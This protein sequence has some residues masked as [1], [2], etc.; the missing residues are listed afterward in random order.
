M[1]FAPTL[2]E[3]LESRCLLSTVPGSV[4]GLLDPSPREQ[5]TLELINRLRADPTADAARLASTAHPDIRR[6]YDIFDV[7]LT[8]FQQQMAAYNPVQ[9]LAWSHTLAAAAKAHNE[10]LIQADIQSHQAPGEPALADRIASAGYNAGVSGENVYAY[11]FDP[12][13]G[14][15]GFVVDWGRGPGGM[16]TPAGHR[17]NML[18]GAYRDVGISILNVPS[19]QTIGPT[20]ITQNFAAPAASA[21]PTLLGVVYAD[22]DNDGFYSMGEGLAN[23]TVTITGNGLNLATGTLSAGSYQAQLPAGTYTITFSGPGFADSTPQLVTLSD[24][25]LKL[26]YQTLQAET[27]PGEEPPPERPAIGYV[28]VLSPTVISGW[29]YD[30]DAGENPIMV[31]IDIDGTRGTPFPATAHRQDLVPVTGSARHGFAVATPA[32]AP[33]DHTFRIVALDTSGDEIVLL[34]TTK[35][36]NTAPAGYL[37][38]LTSTAAAGWAYDPDTDASINIALEIDGVVRPASIAA[39]SRPDVAA[40]VGSANH[41][42]HINLPALTPGTHTVRLLAYD[43]RA[44]TPA[45]L[46]TRTLSVS[47]AM[48]VNNIPTGSRRPFG[49]VDV[50]DAHTLFGW[51]ADPD[52]PN[53]PVQMRIDV[54]GTAAATFTTAVD[55]PDLLPF[56]G[57]SLHGF[58]RATPSLPGPDTRVDVW[59][60]DV[61]TNVPV[62]LASR[63]FQAQDPVGYVDRLAPDRIAGWAFD[64]T[65][66]ALAL[67]IRVDIAGLPSITL[68]ADR[69]RADL[70]AAFGTG[71]HAFSYTPANVPAGTRLV[72]L[73]AIN[74]LTGLSTTLAQKELTF[75]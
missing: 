52:S 6:A 10:V 40:V 1:P 75:A 46:A 8:L 42:F 3:H 9:P 53:T 65:D 61:Q 48:V 57:T 63:I 33:G 23:A 27:P 19:G 26:D 18:H 32:V 13:Y 56:L 35:S 45:V 29:A 7:D 44:N 4:E 47:E 54:N 20:T 41:G 24:Q 68:S 43:A 70:E 36:V 71:N 60:L 49:Y 34:E 17:I 72:T 66:P 59:A 30:P 28:D 55:R 62:L 16:Q 5:Y 25:N 21:N 37:D 73:T 11:A 15:A 22:R 74:P 38:L 14:H 64:R 12:L 51:V 67:D 39:R 2:L 50:F 69:F 31:R 58:H